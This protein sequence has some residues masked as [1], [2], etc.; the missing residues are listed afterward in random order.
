MFE[1]QSASTGLVI[2]D[3]EEVAEKILWHS[4]TL[5]C[6]SRFTFQ[7]D[8]PGLNQDDMLRGIELIGTKVIPIVNKA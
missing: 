2:G 5:G 8:N 1:V 7:M 6:I 3:P 4:E